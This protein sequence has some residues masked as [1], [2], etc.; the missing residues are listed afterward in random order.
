MKT[1]IF[2]T[3]IFSSIS[4]FAG[5]EG[6][7][8][9]GFVCRD[10]NG[11][12]TSVELLDLWEERVI[13]NRKALVLTGDLQTNL[14][15]VIE[16][17]KNMYSEADLIKPDGKVWKSSEQTIAELTF[18]AQGI[19]G[20]SDFANVQRFHGVTLA[21][22][23]DSFEDMVPNQPGCRLE[24][25][26]RLT[27]TSQWQINMDLVS[28]MDQTN[29]IAFGLHEAIYDFLK[30]R[31]AES[32]SLRVRRIVGR[33]MSGESFLAIDEQL[34]KP[35]IKCSSD[36]SK[37]VQDLSKIDPFMAIAYFRAN[38]ATFYLTQNPRSISPSIRV[39]VERVGTL[40]PIDFNH[41]DVA[42]FQ[43]DP[44]VTI[45][46]Y[47]KAIH[48]KT[49]NKNIS[50]SMAGHKDDVEFKTKIQIGFAS[51]L[52]RIQVTDATGLEKDLP[53]LRNLKCDL[54]K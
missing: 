25:I 51:G 34:K 36:I 53:E 27:N 12:V 14:A 50:I 48:D 17:A 39:I 7:G 45:E 3:L 11:N 18:T 15:S 26:A 33:V 32:D 37:K 49:K 21:D 44:N 13:R 2:I 54:V 4:A 31:T 40:V 19:V 41:Q 8:G 38:N 1:I 35:Y 29:L 23:K 5:R 10:S 16:R 47:F 24:Q 42:Y 28:K 46:Q 52:A 22:T 43:A 20:L 30:I 9:K 6:G